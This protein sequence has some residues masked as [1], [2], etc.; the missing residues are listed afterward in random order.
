M[1]KEYIQALDD[2]LGLV[3]FLPRESFA[4]AQKYF[5]ILEPALQRLEAIDNAK[6]SEALECFDKIYYTINLNWNNDL[7]RVG[8]DVRNR[9][10]CYDD[11][12]MANCLDTIKQAL[13]QAERDKD[14]SVETM[15]ALGSLLFIEDKLKDLRYECNRTGNHRCDDLFVPAHHFETIRH[16]LKQKSKKNLEFDKIEKELEEMFKAKKLHQD[17]KIIDSDYLTTINGRLNNIY[18]WQ[19]LEDNVPPTD[20]FGVN[21]N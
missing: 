4:R 11:K 13:I 17:G 12:E 15:E 20:A 5:D 21:R 18:S 16:A 2:L 7:L 6:P 9:S 10:D 19:N 3:A 1:S 8:I 14:N